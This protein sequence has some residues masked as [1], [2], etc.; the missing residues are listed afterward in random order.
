MFCEKTLFI[1]NNFNILVKTF[2]FKISIINKSMS[3]RYATGKQLKDPHGFVVMGIF[4]DM[5]NYKIYWNDLFRSNT[6]Q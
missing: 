1:Y 2:S 5:K 6:S 3:G 4:W